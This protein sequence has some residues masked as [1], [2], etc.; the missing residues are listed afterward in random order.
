MDK[1]IR[2]QYIQKLGVVLLDADN[3]FV[4]LAHMQAKTLAVYQHC[5]L[6][7]KKGTQQRIVFLI[8]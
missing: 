2:K 8:N 7:Q 1:E 6:S 5:S 4:E 3:Y